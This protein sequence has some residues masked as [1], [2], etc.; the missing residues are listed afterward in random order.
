[1]T[2]LLKISE[3]QKSFHDG[4]SELTILKGASLELNKGE[5]VALVGQ[6]GSGK[7]TLLQIAGLLDS[8]N[9]G[10]VTILSEKA[11]EMSQ[12]RKAQV[13]NLHIGFVYQHHHLLPEFTALENVLM[14]QRIATGFLSDKHK[15]HAR[16]LLKQVGLE[17]R[18]SHYPSELSGG[19]QQ[20]VA[21]ARALMCLPEI[22]LAD[23]PTGNLDPET[24]AEVE[25]LFN[26]LCDEMGVGVLYV[27]HDMELAKTA[28]RIYKI[29]NGVVEVV[30]EK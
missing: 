14:P 8:A 27:T 20:R 23:E 1:M 21:I 26:E 24:S 18:M 16:T 25:A 11:S 3:I 4:R 12:A 7:S 28:D 30:S 9:A 5:K 22:L 2:N 15:A 13:R 6:S 17:N 19:E 10:E 29:A